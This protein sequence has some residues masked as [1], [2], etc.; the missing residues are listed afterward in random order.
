MLQSIREHTQGWFAGIVISLLIL[1][2]ALWGIHSYLGGSGSST[3]VAK[4]NGVAITK[5]QYAMA[6]ERLRRQLQM[7]LSSNYAMPEDAEMKLKHNAL[8]TLIEIQVLKQASV[9][10]GYRV[11]SEQVDNYLENMQEFR[12]NGQFSVDRFQQ[13]IATTLYNPQD[14]LELIKTSLLIEQPRLGLI[15]TAFALPDEIKQAIALINQDRDVI[16]ATLPVSQFLKETIVIPDDQI[17]AYYRAHEQDFKTLEQVSVAYVELSIKNLIQDMHP[18]EQALKT[19]YADNTGLFTQ[20]MQWKL[21]SILVPVKDSATDA[22]VKTA[23]TAAKDLAQQLLQGKTVKSFEHQYPA[24]P[25]TQ[26]LSGWVTINKVPAVLQKNILALNTHN[27]VIMPVR[28]Q[29]GFLIVKAVDFKDAV[30]QPFNTVKAK[31]QEAL[32]RQQA[33]EKFANLKEQLANITYEHPD[34]LAPA[35]KLLG[36]PVETSELFSKDK[37]GKDISANSKIRDAA[38]S[39][40][41]LNL[42]NNSDL[43]VMTT[44]SIIVLRVKSHAPATLLS[45]QSVSKQ[46]QDKLKYT[47]ADNKAQQ[48]AQEIVAK[49]QKGASLEE[50]AKAYHL[51]WNTAGYLGRHSNKVSSSVLETAFML[52]KPEASKMTYGVAKEPSAYAVV[53]LRGVKEGDINSNKD[54]YEVFAEQV[55]GSE[56]LL[57][58]ELFKQSLVH[59]AKVVVEANNGAA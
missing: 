34:S 37:G 49:L 42:Q 27:Q 33:E 47:A 58:Y 3:V 35:A 4:V 44:D 26:A 7:Q 20:A 38:F 22:E 14:F 57:E 9:E 8:Q 46:I 31:V 17:A 54:Q 11:S 51:T 39:N 15:F 45:L 16:Y 28:I 12:V 10:Q 19:F 59:Q 2:F 48:Q 6:Y 18:T 40:E 53:T 50:M 36:V 5:D 13:V 43:I 25:M 1:S 52:P 41:V 24:V 30:V 55:Q 56:G 23:E 21:E 32:L 29:Q